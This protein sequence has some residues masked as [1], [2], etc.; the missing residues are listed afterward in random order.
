MRRWAHPPASTVARARLSIS[1]AT[2]LIDEI[3]AQTPALLAQG[4]AVNAI[5]TDG[6][7]RVTVRVQR[8][9]PAA[10][11]LSARFN[12]YG[13]DTVTVAQ[14][15]PARAASRDSDASP[16]KAGAHIN[17]A[18]N[19]ATGK[20]LRCSSGFTG[21]S[22]T[23]HARYM[24]TAYHC[25]VRSDP[26]FWTSDA[27]GVKHGS[28]IGTA[29]V[30]D[31][32]HDIAYVRV[33]GGSTTPETWDG[34]IYPKTGQFRKPVTLM[35]FPERGVDNSNMRRVCTSG[36]F[37]GARCYATVKGGGWVAI[38]LNGD[39][40]GDYSS[41]LWQADSNDGSSIAGHG[42]SGGPVFIPNGSEVTAIGMVSAIG[43]ANAVC[44]GDADS[45]SST[46]FFTDVYTEAWLNHDIFLNL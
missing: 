6:G 1:Q 3:H 19:P 27:S 26:R 30:L 17:S 2:S 29:T 40:V 22:T 13:A 28:F 43:P 4:I 20:P 39:G 44:T 12:R 36:A 32:D 11:A 24:I 33:T 9:T 14:G 5:T 37:S 7:G 16:F 35:N 15:E 31:R 46:V 45:C 42:D 21:E 38:D 25:V 41:W 10:L 8:L 18:I 34:A 23:N